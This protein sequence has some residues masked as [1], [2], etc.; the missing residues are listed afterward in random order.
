MNNLKIVK[1]DGHLALARALGLGEYA[2]TPN[3][4]TNLTINVGMSG[5]PTDWWVIEPIAVFFGQ[6]GISAQAMHPNAALLAANF[7]LSREAQTQ[8]TRAGRIPVRKDVTPNP[9]DLYERFGKAPVITVT[10]DSED[11]KKWKGITQQLLG[12]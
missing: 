1:L 7:T 2:A 12:R 6:V 3:N 8:L 9:S 10:F 4:Y 11:E 5:N